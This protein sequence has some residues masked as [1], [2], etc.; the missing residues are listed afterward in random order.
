MLFVAAGD[1]RALRLGCG[2]REGRSKEN[3]GCAN[4]N[5]LSGEDGVGD[6]GVPEAGTVD[7]S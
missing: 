5:G 6:T 3:G 2:I 7:R 1:V 4:R